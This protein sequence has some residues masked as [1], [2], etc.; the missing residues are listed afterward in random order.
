VAS[1]QKR[2]GGQGDIGYYVENRG[3]GWREDEVGGE[4]K[5]RT[6]DQDII[7]MRM[8]PQWFRVPVSDKAAIFPLLK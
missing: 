1:R 7:L 5:I 3:D 4:K 8:A 2:R 6:E